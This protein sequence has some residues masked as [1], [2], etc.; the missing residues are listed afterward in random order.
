MPNPFSEENIPFQ[1]WKHSFHK[2]DTIFN[3]F[4]KLFFSWGEEAQIFG[5]KLPHPK[6]DRVLVLLVVRFELGGT[7]IAPDAPS[8]RPFNPASAG[9][10]KLYFQFNPTHYY[11][12]TN[13]DWFSCNLID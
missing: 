8:T 5:W 9:P 11:G 12:T 4:A 7:D 1:K 6:E 3:T 10:T 2:K 13:S